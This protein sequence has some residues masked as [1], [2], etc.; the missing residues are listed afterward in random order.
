MRHKNE[1][2]F[3]IIPVTCQNGWG[4]AQQKSPAEDHHLTGSTLIE[5]LPNKIGVVYIEYVAAQMQIATEQGERETENRD[6]EIWEWSSNFRTTM[7]LAKIIRPSLLL[8]TRTTYSPNTTHIIDDN[9][10]FNSLPTFLLAHIMCSFLHS[11]A[12]NYRQHTEIY[13]HNHLHLP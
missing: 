6:D 11:D 2:L 5:L 10:T 12:V 9:L 1:D 7:I 13:S 4:K 3:W 8:I